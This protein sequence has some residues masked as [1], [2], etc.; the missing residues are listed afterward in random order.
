[1]TKHGT[2]TGYYTGGCRCDECRAAASEYRK[3]YRQGRRIRKEK[4]AE[5]VIRHGTR[6]GYNYDKCRCD[7]CRAYMA[8]EARAYRVSRG[9]NPKP[10]PIDGCAIDGCD[11]EHMAKGLC[12]M[13]YYR[14]RN[15]GSAGMPSPGRRANG[16]GCITPDGYHHLR[17]NAIHRTVMAEHIGRPLL[18]HENVHHKNGVRTD[19]RI[20]NLE[21]WSKSQ[22]AGQRVVDKIAWAE[23]I[24][25]TYHDLRQ[26]SLL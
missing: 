2:S 7:E 13:H 22:P 15:T 23:E 12:R 21:L 8:A 6:S 26:L 4:S 17:G 16:E 3:Q 25:A 1:M 9:A 18:S 5:R 24:L 20:E 14:V 19:N 10:P 11:R